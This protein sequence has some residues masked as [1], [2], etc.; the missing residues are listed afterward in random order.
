[1]KLAEGQ[2]WAPKGAEKHRRFR[3]VKLYKD[4]IRYVD[5]YDSGKVAVR[6]TSRIQWEL[7]V[8]TGALVPS[9]QPKM[10]GGK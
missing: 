9:S 7:E 4:V 5:Y 3:I 8:E 10:K 1:M 2:W 6:M